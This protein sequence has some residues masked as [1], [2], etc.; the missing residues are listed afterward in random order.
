M[1]ESFVAGSVIRRE[2]GHEK[3]GV[4]YPSAGMIQHLRLPSVNIILRISLG[5]LV[6]SLF[7][8][9]LFICLFFHCI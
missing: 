8:M 1:L 9:F 4:E 5:G 6:L 7:A 3:T 2:A